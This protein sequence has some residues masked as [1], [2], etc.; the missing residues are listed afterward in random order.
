[1][2]LEFDLSTLSNTSTKLT[3]LPFTCSN[4]SS[5]FGP[6]SVILVQK[7]STFNLHFSTF[8]LLRYVLTENKLRFLPH[9]NTAESR[10][11]RAGIA[12]SHVEFFNLTTLILVHIYECKLMNCQASV[13]PF[14]VCRSTTVCRLLYDVFLGVDKLLPAS[15]MV[16]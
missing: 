8:V 12:P 15:R 16:H 14:Y 11:S 2:G 13:P 10:W 4:N 7:K 6:M 3:S 5:K 9:A 1:L